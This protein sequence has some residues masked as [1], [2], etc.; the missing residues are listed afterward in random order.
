[1]KES[2]SV[3][4]NT[5]IDAEGSNQLIAAAT[6]TFSPAV[7]T[8]GLLGDVVRFAR[9]GVAVNITRLAK[10]IADENNLIL[11]APPLKFLAPFYEKASLE[12]TSNTDAH[13]RW[14]SLL[15]GASSSPEEAKPHFVHLLAQLEPSQVQLLKACFLGVGAGIDIGSKHGQ[16]LVEESFNA[17]TNQFSTF[18]CEEVLDLIIERGASLNDHRVTFSKFLN[19]P[20]VFISQFSARSFEDSLS[21]VSWQQR[22]INSNLD[23]DILTSL[24]LLEKHRYSGSIPILNNSDHREYFEIDFLLITKLGA[25]FVCAFDLEAKR[26]LAEINSKFQQ[27][28][29]GPSGH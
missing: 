16:C 18:Y 13:E 15:V 24:G 28:R 10:K 1:M 6:E 25:N 14:A 21:K 11:N 3:S 17:L 22:P 5:D 8:L 19:G 20:G 9:V 26:Y 2:I 4:V 29:P 23:A 12:T 7:E 27:A